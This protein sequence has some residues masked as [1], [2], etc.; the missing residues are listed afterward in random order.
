MLTIPPHPQ[1]GSGA[2]TDKIASRG[3][4][5]CLAPAALSSEAGEEC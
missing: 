3:R 4:K 2:E 1:G 5:D